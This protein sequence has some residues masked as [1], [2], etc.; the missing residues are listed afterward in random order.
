MPGKKSKILEKGSYLGRTERNKGP[1]NG[2]MRKARILY[3]NWEKI[4]SGIG[5]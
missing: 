2:Q 4:R 3:E 5:R 1:F